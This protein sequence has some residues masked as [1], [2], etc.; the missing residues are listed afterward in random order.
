MHYLKSI[1]LIIL[2]TSCSIFAQTSKKTVWT[3]ENFSGLEFRSI[4]PAFMSGRISDIAFH[5]DNESVWY[6]T[7]GSGN[8]WKTVNAGVTW[9]P[10]FDNQNSYSTG[11]VTLDP[12][13]PNTVWVGTGEN[14]GGRHFGYGDGVYR[15][16]DGGQS[17]KNMGLKKSEH[18]SEI[19]I[20]PENSNIIWVASQGP[21]WSSGG[22]RGVY[23]SING[24][25]TWSLILKSNKWTGATELVMDPRNPDRIYAV[26]WQRHRTVAAYMGG[27]P[28]TG[29]YRTDDGGD[30]WKKLSSGLPSSNMG[31]IG[32]DISKHN[33]DIVYA[34][35]EL[36]RRKGGVYKSVDRGETW[37]KQSD[38]VAGGTGPHYYQE[39]YASPHHFDKLFLMNNY[40]L[41]SDDGGK[42][43]SRMNEKHKHVDNHAIAF[44]K[45]DPN[46]VM[47]G[48]DGGLYES[49]DLTKTWRFISNLPITQ[50]YDLALDDAKPF[51][52]VFGGTQ[53]NSSEGGPSR[54]DNRQGIQ[55]G[56]WR[57]ILGGDGHQ[58]ATE[59]GNPDIMYAQSQQ[60]YLNRLDM[61]TGETVFIQ[62]Q[63]REGEPYERFNWDA[64]IIV[65]PHKPS[66]IYFASQ[67]VW[68]SD[69][70]GDSWTPISKDLTRNQERFDLPIM[71]SKQSWDNPWDVLAMSNYNTI[72]AISESPVKEGLIYAGTD[73]GY[74]NVTDN[75]GKSW[76][77]FEVKR[78]PGAPEMAYVNDLKADNFDAN[79][80]YAVL[81]NHKYGDYKAYVYKSTN[82][83]QT[84]KSIS[85]NLPERS[86][87]WRII[88]DHVKKDLL[89]LGTEFG[90]YFSVDS[91]DIWTQLSGNV[92]TIPFRDLAIHK[93]EN[94]LVGATFGR[95]FYVFDDMSVFRSISDTQ[96]KSKATLF[97]VRKALWYIP[98]S[99]LGGSG[100]ASQGDGYY[101]APNP[102]FGAVF[103][104]HLSESFMTKAEKRRNNE[105]KSSK[106]VGFPGWDEVEAERREI[107]PKIIFEV[108]DSGGDVVRRIDA[109]ASKGFHR[110]AWDL[111]YPNPYALPLDREKVTGSG[112]LAMPGKYSVTM[113]SVV[114]GK[115]QK[116]SQPQQFDVTPLRKGALPS[117]DYAE[118]FNFLRGVEKT[119]KKVTAIQI[120]VTNTLKK[121]KSMNVALAQSNADVGVMDEELSKL[122]DS[123][124]EMDE[125]LNGNRSK[126]EPGE[127]NNPTVYTRLYTA[128]RIA[129]GSTYGPTTLALDNL[130]LANKRIDLI[131]KQLTAN[132]Q[133]IIDLSYELRQAGAPWVEGDELPD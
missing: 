42:N 11:C 72:S 19:L 67:R 107:S 79:T 77:K 9:T 75:D 84:W 114:D 111:R 99:S 80:V 65:S 58:P 109:P 90:V 68:K 118:T 50:F 35:I 126:N 13:N 115:T 53:D 97:P 57:V 39:L 95:G 88:Q 22:E 132:N 92:P 81:D 125:E 47:V 48:S 85:S 28:G 40:M 123:L 29:I 100:K 89:F 86:H 98:R 32:F 7:V 61:T 54:T 59:P 119:F 69:D 18:I 33:S 130:S 15:S 26:L 110:V 103:T 4:G 56:D 16:T 127:K 25:K 20:H 1:S 31:K 43:F 93:R 105:K 83:G 101:I 64:P 71:G 74:I 128:A 73:D 116:L 34:A 76:K 30:N 122:R 112:Y 131:E 124:L 36:D 129:S 70:R 46:Y 106:S 91:G 17:W 8:V 38:A 62:P 23:K 82:K 94:D 78:L 2:L 55:N 24:G 104:Y 117:K 120:S 21:M 133:M 37:T 96:M 60:G 63:P 3:K 102:P 5:P 66:R 113:Y 44:K 12:R 41:V 87:S 108:R 51:Y 121:V 49:F 10:I 45:S 52:N 6:V 14:L 27:G